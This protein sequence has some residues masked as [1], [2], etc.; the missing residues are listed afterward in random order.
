MDDPK[1]LVTE[2]TELRDQK[3]V[4]RPPGRTEGSAAL[5]YRNAGVLEEPDNRGWWRNH[6]DILRYAGG[7]LIGG[8]VLALALLLFARGRVPLAEGISGERVKRFGAIERAN[9]WMTAA[10]FLVMAASGLV[11][12]Y[13]KPL[14]LPVLGEP[15]F[16]QVAWLIAWVHMASAVPFVIGVLVMAALGSSP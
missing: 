15:T 7:W 4:L 14:L 11:I 10:A 3:D 6:N 13:G 5:P 16:G 8:V 12:L 1:Q 9:H 2:W